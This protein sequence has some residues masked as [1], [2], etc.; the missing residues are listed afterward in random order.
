MNRQ[1]VL[2]T[3]GAKGIGR[4]IV[5]SLAGAG[6]DVDFTCRASASAGADLIAELRAAFPE[7]SFQVRHVDLADRLQ[8][9]RNDRQSQP[10][11]ES[12]AP[13]LF[14]SAIPGGRRATV[15]TG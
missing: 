2:V 14:R 7:Q 12:R 8:A 10:I 9:G 4:E 3:G 6:Y 11:W 5:R 15:L 13:D 1:G